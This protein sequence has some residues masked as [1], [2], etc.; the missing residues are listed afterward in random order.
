M[1]PFARRRRNVGAKPQ[2]LDIDGR[3]I[4]VSNLEKVLYP[5]GRLRKG[6]VLDYYVRVSEFLLPHLRD[7]PVT[8][9]RY[10]DGVTGEHFFE[11]DAPGFTPEWVTTFPVPRRAGGAD[12]R[13][14]IVRDLAT[15]VWIANL[16]SLE[17][18][19]FL[20]RTSDLER[21]SY[22]VFDLD[23]GEGA[24]VLTCARVAFSLR[25]LLADL[26]LEC[27]AKVSGSKGLQVYVP[28]NIDIT[29]EVTK[30]FAKGVAE[31][32]HARSPKLVVAEMAKSLRAGRVFIDWSQNDDYKTTVSVYSLRAK[33][34]KPFVS[35]PVTW[36]ELESAV[37]AERKEAL[38]FSPEGTLARL[39]EL[40]DL[41]APVLEMRQRL[42]DEIMDAFPRAKSPRRRKPG[43]L[44]TYAAKRDFTKT[45]EPAGQPATRSRQGSRRRFV[46]QKHAA[47]HLHYDFR[48]EMHGVLKSWAVPK[49]P[50]LVADEARLAMATEDHPVEY[51]DF[52]GIIPKGEYGGGTVMVW[53]IGTYD[54]IEGNYYKGFLHVHLKGRKLDGE[55]KLESDED[56]KRWRWTRVTGSDEDADVASGGSA[57]QSALTGRTMKEIADAADREWQS[58]RAPVPR[59]GGRGVQSG[60][61][62]TAR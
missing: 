44:E 28:L 61:R 6:E 8:L 25:A 47:S 3:Q 21:P 24:D 39:D 17:I 53:D 1:F 30:P 23:P 56:R 46:V 41:F 9:V 40:G 4:P 20:H 37:R 22:V 60:R 26:G 33:N 45:R 19:P 49:G 13:Y 11:K 7:R 52:E 31:M 2:H 10:P 57:D 35:M 58:N 38:F 16:A 48:L 32:L 51:L 36:D 15:L 34:L 27:F 55:W 59:S 50:P 12:I 18:H 42:P 54:V 62:K 43:S 5:G 14:I 29:Y